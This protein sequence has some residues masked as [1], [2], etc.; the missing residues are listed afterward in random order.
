MS[1]YAP[2]YKESDVRVRNICRA[3]PTTWRKSASIDM[4]WRNYVTVTLCIGQA[5]ALLAIKWTV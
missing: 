4:I 3:W 5:H 1:V 2:S